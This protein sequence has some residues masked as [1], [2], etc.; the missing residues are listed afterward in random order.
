MVSA[1]WQKIGGVEVCVGDDGVTGVYSGDEVWAIASNHTDW[2]ATKAQFEAKHCQPRHR[3]I[4]CADG[5]VMV[6]STDEV[7]GKPRRGA[8]VTEVGACWW[9]DRYSEPSGNYGTKDQAIAAA[10]AYVTAL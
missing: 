5:A 4:E 9:V 7:D 3:L 6:M 10:V 1:E 2:M 8:M